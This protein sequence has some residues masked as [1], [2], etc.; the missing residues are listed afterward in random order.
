M[1]KLHPFQQYQQT[2]TQYIRDPKTHERPAKV[3][4]KR[5]AI[6]AEIVYDNIDSTLSACF[7][8]AKNVLGSRKWKKL[9]RAFLAEYQSQTP[10]F[11][12]IPK[13]FLHYLQIKNTSIEF[14]NFLLD[15]MHYEWVELYLSSMEVELP[16]ALGADLQ[17]GQPVIN[18]AHLLLAYDYPVHTISKRNQPKLTT[19]TYLLMFR[20]HDYEIKFV[21]LNAITFQLLRLIKEKPSSGKNLLLALANQMQH[22]EPEVFIKFGLQILQ[23]L[24]QQGAVAGTL[25]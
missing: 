23:D 12:E 21:L 1:L 2:F 25:P 15:L 11:R 4:A 16:N 8:V 17:Y 6:Y 24:M 9:T 3:S 20:K 14:P 19:P 13:Q 5:M 10:I 22:P 7:P 18:P